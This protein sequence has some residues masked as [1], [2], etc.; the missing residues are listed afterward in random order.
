MVLPY[1]KVSQVVHPCKVVVLIVHPCTV[2]DL[3]HIVIDLMV[4]LCVVVEGTIASKSWGLWIDREK[5]LAE[6]FSLD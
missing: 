3:L 6:E 5:F 4:P 2:M 1:T